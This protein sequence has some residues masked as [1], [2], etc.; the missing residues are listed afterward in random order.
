MNKFFALFFFAFLF[1][2]FMQG[3][4]SA[5]GR[6]T[7]LGKAYLNMT[8]RYNAY[9]H[10]G[11][12][13][14]KANENLRLQHR[15]NFNELLPMY[16]DIANPDTNAVKQEADNA[17]K[18]LAT[19]IELRRLSKWTDNSYL[20]MGQAEFMKQN[21]E[22]AAATFK[23]VI[24]KYNPDKPKSLMSKEELAEYN[25]KQKNT[26]KSTSSSKDSKSSAGKTAAQRQKEAAKKKKAEANRIK[27]AKAK[28]RKAEAKRK[29]EAAKLKK[30]NAKR[31]KAG[32]KPLPSKNTKPS[33]DKDKKDEPAVRTKAEGKLSLVDKT[34]E[35]KQKNE[36]SEDEMLETQKRDKQGLLKHKPVRHAAML[37]LAKSSIQNK[38]YNNAGLYLRMLD[39]DI[40]TPKKLQGEVKAVQAHLYIVQ[41]EY[42]K[43]IEQLEL[44]VPLTKKRK[45]RRARYAYILA[46]LYDKT[47]N[48]EE[49]YE[50]YKAVIKL[51]PSYEMD[52]NARLSLAKAGAKTGTTDTDPEMAMR[53]MLREDKNEEYKGQIYF[54]LAEVQLRKGKLED[55]IESLQKSMTYSQTDQQRLEASYLLAGLYFER[56][57]YLDAYAYYDTTKQIMKPEDAR[58]NEVQ[59]RHGQLKTYAV[60]AREYAINDSL[61]RISFLP[62]DQQKAYVQQIRK[63]EAEAAKAG[64]GNKDLQR[65]NVSKTAG[66]TISDNALAQS[67]FPLYNNNQVKKGEKDFEKRWGS[68][69]W[70]DNWR[71]Q[72]DLSSSGALA[73]GGGK[74]DV[75]PLTEKEFSDYL[76]KL[77]IPKDDKE[78]EELQK[79]IASNLLNMGTAQHEQL[80]QSEKAVVVLDT[81]ATRYPKYPQ[82]LD[83]LYVMYSIY[84]QLG[85]TAKAQAVKERI[86]K[87]HANSAVAQIVNDPSKLN[88]R[89][90][91]E[92]AIQTAYESAYKDLQ[93]KNYAQAKSKSEAAL[94]TYATENTPYKAKFA[95][96]TAMSIGALEGEDAYIK[97]LRVVQ[98]S[99]P[100]TAEAKKAKEIL[101]ILGKG[102]SADDNKKSGA[103]QDKRAKDNGAEGVQ[104]TENMNT[105]HYVII[106]FEDTKAKLEPLRAPIDAFNKDNFASARLNVASIILE[107]KIPAI[108]V[109]KFANGADAVNY[110]KQARN[111]PNYLG[112][113]APKGNIYVV[114]QDNYRILLQPPFGKFDDYVKFHNDF[115]KL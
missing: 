80:A 26:K 63:E 6:P 9:Y 108:T 86:N 23:Y 13:V 28:Q 56:E 22:K 51:K 111:A 99:F 90:E 39:E 16:L 97:A 52:L 84:Q 88:A 54:T 45:G 17:I 43:A 115:Y 35:K 107:N 85:Q 83:G 38:D 21:Y 48:T 7:K 41:K 55:G 73:S 29:K 72:N 14:D 68:R 78:R 4:K 18:K 87:D 67:N 81:L 102:S 20:M 74:N 34:K 66:V 113:D 19:N 36:I 33:T 106:V 94:A 104:F 96:V 24:D 46:Q 65:L 103:P 47:G 93:D 37:W 10:A 30:K 69:P 110:V 8:G 27:K 79:K 91:K 59:T 42:D 2:V 101:D 31:K 100:E 98:T 15:D 40:N 76:T 53:K 3:C 60:N 58:I 62:I 57:N 50:Q 82:A 75:A 95:L 89:Q 109:R 70:A 114:G 77:K 44:A 25:K 64:N 5:D 71:S 12:L 105:G 11:L 61:L 92:K 1:T 32:K 112:K 49:A